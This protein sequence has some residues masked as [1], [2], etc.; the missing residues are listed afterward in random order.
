MGGLTPSWKTP[1]SRRTTRENRPRQRSVGFLRRTCKSAA[2]KLGMKWADGTGNFQKNRIEPAAAI[3]AKAAEL[4][5][6]MT[7]DAA[8][9]RA[10]YSFVSTQYRYIGI[11]FGIGRFQPHAAED[12]LSNNYGD[13]KD[14]H[15]LLASLLQASGIT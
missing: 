6:G 10:L 12:V 1:R 7:D 2:S 5:K 14:K 3:R 4:T 11:A 8:K 15:T 9:L 13:C